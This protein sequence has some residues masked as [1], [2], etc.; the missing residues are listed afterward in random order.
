MSRIL[1]L[2]TS[3]YTGSVAIGIQGNSTRF[4]ATDSEQKNSEEIHSL[5]ESVL[6]N[7][8]IG[9]TELDAIAVSAGPGSYTGL[10]IGVS[11]AKGLCFAL[12]KPLIA[13]ST[14][15]V[16]ASGFI[17]R[18]PGFE[19]FICPMLDARRL[20]VYASVF[21]HQLKRIAEDQ[22][23]IM[24]QALSWPFPVQSP[25]CFLGNGVSKSIPYLGMFSQACF[26]PDATPNASDMAKLA[27]DKWQAQE[28]QDL[29]WFE[30]AYLKPFQ[31]KPQVT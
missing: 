16:M 27:E 1:L 14:L 24:D 6:Q 29:A 31:G 12:N 19:G 7:E 5:I 10:R 22:P 26:L 2:E 3:S 28:F 15:E 23:M 20:E 30:P 18:N 8:G 21:N 13:V 4:L 11:L 9:Y 25:V 17:L